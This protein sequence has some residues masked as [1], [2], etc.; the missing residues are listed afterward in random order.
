MNL[1]E[2]QMVGGRCQV[3]RRLSDGLYQVLDEGGGRPARRCLL[4]LPA[5]SSDLRVPGEPWGD[6]PP[7]AGTLAVDG[8]QW[9]LLDHP[10]A[11]TLAGAPPQ[12]DESLAR[13]LLALLDVLADLHQRGAATAAAQLGHFVPGGGE[14]RLAYLGPVV[15]GG[16]ESPLRSLARLVAPLFEGGLWS[17]ELAGW[18]Q[19]VANGEFADLASAGAALERLV[20][21]AELVGASAFSSETGP[22]RAE[23]QDAVLSLEQAWCAG[24]QPGQWSLRALADGVGGHRG[25]AQ[26]ARLALHTL[27]SALTT[28]EA[29]VTL[30][31]REVEWASNAL[32]LV[33]L[34]HAVQ[35]AH[36]TV[37]GLTE[38]GE[39]HPPGTTLVATLRVGARLFV[40]HVGDSR[41]YL[42]RGGALWPLTTDHNLAEQLIAAGSHTAA[43]AHAHPEAALLTQ[44]LG[45]SGELEPTFS[46]RLLQPGDRVLLCTDGVLETLSE[47]ELRRVLAEPRPAVAAALATA[48]AGARGGT[49]NATA[50]VEHYLAGG[51][52]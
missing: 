47:D 43:A 21:A 51:A 27:A 26:A 37:Q 17:V 23:N 31:G 19:T 16:G 33:E 40:A 5:G 46:V 22:V 2:G 30:D 44:C 3:L 29:V 6:L 8:A 12:A 11:H 34:S 13:V 52:E 42:L 38:A 14:G 45:Q 32:V 28:A 36:Q 10:G 50:L 9:L 48:T 7:S 49:D 15:A 20:P 41:A 25:G 18:G 24:S 35:A 39:E 1:H 4:E